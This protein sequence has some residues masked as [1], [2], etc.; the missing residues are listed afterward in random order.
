MKGSWRR[1][2]RASTR[3]FRIS[4][5]KVSLPKSPLFISSLPSISIQLP[6]SSHEPVCVQF[7][8]SPSCLAAILDKQTISR[9]PNR[10]EARSQQDARREFPPVS[11]RRSRR[12]STCAIGRHEIK[13][14][15]WL[16]HSHSS[17]FAKRPTVAISFVVDSGICRSCKRMKLSLTQDENAVASIQMEGSCFTIHGD[18]DCA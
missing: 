13:T 9:R 11:V 16:G 14:S 8:P 15:R 12:M 6:L 3:Y 7:A 17:R 5:N 18:L 4:M 2:E 1:L 10:A